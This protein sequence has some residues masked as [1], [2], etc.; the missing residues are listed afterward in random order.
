MPQADAE[1]R[2]ALLR[3]LPD[4]PGRVVDR[5]RVARTVREGAERFCAL[6][7]SLDKELGAFYEGL[8]AAEKR[9]CEVYLALARA[10]GQDSVE[11]RIRD[12]AAADAELI[13]QP[14][15]RFGF[16]SGPPLNA[17]AARA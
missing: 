2:R 11:A 14:D 3:D 15:R 12:F 4:V 10:R 13:T 8:F 6:A 9:H 1:D 7:P 16:H 5:R 17:G